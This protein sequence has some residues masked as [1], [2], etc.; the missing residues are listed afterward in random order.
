M[1]NRTARAV[2]LQIERHCD[3]SQML[4]TVYAAQAAFRFDSFARKGVLHDE[5]NSSRFIGWS[6]SISKSLMIV[7]LALLTTMANA[8]TTIPAKAVSTGGNSIPAPQVQQ[9]QMQCS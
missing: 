7:P 9:Q 1:Q 4:S 3:Q 8:Q 2:P 6:V 5:Y